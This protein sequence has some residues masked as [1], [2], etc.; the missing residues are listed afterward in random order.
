MDGEKA[1]VKRRVQTNAADPR[2]S[3][4]GFGSFFHVWQ[5]GTAS[6]Q[7]VQQEFQ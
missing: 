7:P 5:C 4:D 2:A 3:E 1:D 6:A